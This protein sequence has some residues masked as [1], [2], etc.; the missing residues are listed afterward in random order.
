MEFNFFNLVNKDFY[1]LNGKQINL[2]DNILYFTLKDLFIKNLI[3]KDSTPDKFNNE[4]NFNY[5][6]LDLELSKTQLLFGLYFAGC[7]GYY[8]ILLDNPDNNTISI[9][10]NILVRLISLLNSA[11]NIETG[12]PVK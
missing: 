4:Y 3:N 2:T 12:R 7:N 6:A 9:F 10:K 8:G 5:I 1:S 11:Y